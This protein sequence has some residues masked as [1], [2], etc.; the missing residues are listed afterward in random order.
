MSSGSGDW[1][2]SACSYRT[3]DGPTCP[4]LFCKNY[5]KHRINLWQPARESLV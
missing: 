2:S 5:L 3:T 4:F 1:R